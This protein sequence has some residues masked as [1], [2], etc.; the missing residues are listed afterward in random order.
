MVQADVARAGPPRRK[1]SIYDKEVQAVV[2]QV[3]VLATVAGIGYYLYSNM[4]ANLSRQNIQTGFEYLGRESGFE[5]GETWIPYSPGSTYAQ[6]LL[7]GFLNTLAVAVVGVVLATT[8]GISVGVSSLSRNWLVRKVTGVYINLLRNVPVL[9]QIILWHTVITNER[10]LPIPRDFLAEAGPKPLLGSIYFTRR[11]IY[12]P[13][14]E[15]HIG[16]M[17]ALIGLIIGIVGAYLVARWARQRM[18]ETGQQFP[19]YWAGLGVIFVCAF[20]GWLMMGAPTTVSYPNIGR[21]RV[22]GGMTITP[23]FMA[24]LFG[25]TIYTSAFVA[26]IVRSGILAVPK[27]Q[28][29]AGRSLGL[30]ESVI[31][32][33]VIL[34]QA[35]R[36]IIPPLTSQYLNLTKNSS[37]AV[38]VGYPDLV[39]VSNTTMNQTGQAP[40]AILIMMI[41]YLAISL[42]T[43][44]L[45]NWYNSR[46]QLVER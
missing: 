4:Q 7:V 5:I 43:S 27:G 21:F 26:E 31:M 1:R 6:A 17:A 34:P 13:T 37:L 12:V 19:A 9:L 36:V 14:F 22:S 23:E 20:V 2:W 39:N 10:F 32:R 25:L 29:E 30:R 18:N 35:L 41:V 42:V 15:A 44:L 8:I 24:V 16:W 28:I 33:Q 45:M 38:A 3:V 46:V 11:G 40:E